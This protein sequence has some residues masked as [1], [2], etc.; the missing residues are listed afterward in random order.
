MLKGKKCYRSDDFN[1]DLLKRPTHSSTSDF[2]NCVFL[3]SFLSTIN[4]PTR[5]TNL[6]AKLINNIITNVNLNNAFSSIIYAD[7]SDNFPVF[8]QTRHSFKHTDKPVAFYKRNF[9]DTAKCNFIAC[10]QQTD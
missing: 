5:V 10:L 3:H 7:I 4:K 6:S 8:L 9:S 1:I 2:I